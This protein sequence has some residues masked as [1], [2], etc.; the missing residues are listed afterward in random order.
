MRYLN[1]L[2]FLCLLLNLSQPAFAN[3]D[4]EG[5]DAAAPTTTHRTIPAAADAGAEDAATDAAAGFAAPY[6]PVRA[7]FADLPVDALHHVMGFSG[8]TEAFA[9]AQGNRATANAYAQHLKSLQKNLIPTPL[10]DDIGRAPVGRYRL[11]EVETR[12][13]LDRVLSQ[14]QI[15]A[16]IRR[17]CQHY[18]YVL[19][20]ARSAMW[21]T[22]E[23]ALGH[24]MEAPSTSLSLSEFMVKRDDTPL[25]KASKACIYAHMALIENRHYMQDEDGSSGGGGAGASSDVVAAESDAA[26]LDISIKTAIQKGFNEAA[27][28]KKFVAWGSELDHA[29]RASHIFMHELVLYRMA[30]EEVSI[31]KNFFGANPEKTLILDTEYRWASAGMKILPQTVKHLVITNVNDDSPE[32][33]PFEAGRSNLETLALRGFHKM[34]RIME[35]F[36]DFHGLKDLSF[37]FHP[38]LTTVMYSFDESGIE[39]LDL[40]ML[41]KT[42]LLDSFNKNKHLKRISFS[43]ERTARLHGFFNL[44][45]L[46]VVELPKETERETYSEAIFENCGKLRTL[47]FKENLNTFALSDTA[48]RGAPIKESTDEET[49]RLL[50]EAFRR[51]DSI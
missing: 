4:D 38:R 2:P 10:G 33:D 37:D 45:S 8:Y 15:N 32:I 25:V 42:R 51:G 29:T 50:T 46:E 48:F 41:A 27:E 47:R 22:L 16:A 14:D 43:Y 36:N 39:T 11:M 9:L 49:K 44:P 18:R 7:S 12:H 21:V 31:L 3:S 23:R 6:A 13:K 20:D 24:G 19:V 17:F 26:I 5:E 35:T 1:I 30:E 40:R 34:Q 28:L